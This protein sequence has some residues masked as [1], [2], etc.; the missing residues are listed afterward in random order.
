M[1]TERIEIIVSERGTRTVRRNI[2]DIGSGATRAEGAVSLLNRALGLI[3]GALAVRELARLADVYTNLQNRLKLVT[4][5]TQNLARVTDEL[6][7]ISNRTRSSY[8]ATAT[9]Y[10]RVALA[11]KDLGISQQELLNFTESLNQAVI[12][13]GASAVEAENAMIQLSQG[14]ASGALRGD[15]LRSVMEQLPYVADVIA[16]QLGVTRG[17]LRKMGEDGK[18][19]ADIVLEAFRNA[20]GE[21]ADNFAKTI[22]TI[23]QSITVLKNNVIE[24][25]GE[26]VTTSGIAQGLSQAI[27]IL[28]NNLDKIIPLVLAVGGAFAAWQVTATIMG[29]LGPMIALERALGATSIAAALAS[30][31]MKGLQGA[32]NGLTAAIAANPLGAILVAVTAAIALFV[33]FGDE[34][35]V[36]EDGVVSLKDVVIAAFQLIWESISGVVAAFQVAWDAAIKAV[37]ALFQAFG[38]TVSAVFSA[39][40]QLAK[41]LINAYIGVWVFAFRAVNLIW[42]NF[43]GFMDALFVQVVNLGAAA[44]EKLLNAWQ[45][46][47]R[48]IA[49]GLSIIDDEA[50]AA[51]SGFLDNFNVTIPRAQVSAAG[52]QFGQDLSAAANESFTTDF[53]GNAVDAV[54]ARARQNAL[55]DQGEESPLAPGGPRNLPAT[56]EDA[57]KK[58]K[59]LEDAE[60]A[61]QRAL[62]D[63]LKDIDREVLLL[64]MSNRERERAEEL[65]RLEDAMKRQLTASERELA[66]AR[67]DSLQAARDN[68]Y[69]S[70]YR[71]DLED[72]NSLLRLTGREHELRSEL[73]SIERD[74][75][76]SLTPVE[77]E[78]L[79]V[80]LQQ[81]AALRGQNELLNATVGA[82]QEMFDKIGDAKT[83][84][85]DPT[86]GF[87]QGDAFS[88]LVG[89]GELGTYF[90]GTKAQMDAQ[91][92][93]YNNQFMQIQ[94]LRDADLI[95]A[96]SY[97]QALGALDSK[98]WEL[99]MTN[100]TKTLGALSGLQRSKVKEVAAIGKAAAVAQ[101]TIDG[102][103]AVQAALRGPPGPPFSYAIAAATAAMTASN[104]AQ[105]LSTP[106][107]FMTGGTMRVGGTGGPDSQMVAFRATPGEQIS[108]KTPAQVRKGSGAFAGEGGGGGQQPARVR[109]VNVIDPREAL[110]A[111]D[112]ADGEQLVTN[113]I[114]RNASTYRR[115]LGAT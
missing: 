76:R 46:P 73:L 54:M 9:M 14:L 2:E 15:E 62:Q 108:V 115:I 96:E 38:T 12:M 10:S 18:I 42:N 45:V 89:N 30:L 72:E 41:A 31:S 22:P 29:I 8:E 44:A 106:T 32:V 68:K 88:Q 74:L 49:Q 33:A 79:T 7:A 53:V 99:R 13:S 11:A 114:E 87:T 59:D 103:A 102:I 39:I 94:A 97:N 75:G 61:A 71:Q 109:V 16:N 111:F 65:Y 6:F 100:A 104:I 63:W 84:V 112:T 4:T 1:A 101:A 98:M 77:R 40:L 69:L 110:A 81:N 58:T 91:M 78:W 90:E 48:L 66:N 34:I 55:A 37:N 67:L 80:L 70:D 47:L 17:E 35:K 50:G 83:L 5:D 52:K 105:I 36:T 19:T 25:W 85:Q 113:I 86:S 82:R 28:A 93:M 20:R 3:G 27:L 107:G 21:L 43:P 23:G 51:L 24:L 57:A 26:F 92:E 64:G 56:L 95:D 60:K